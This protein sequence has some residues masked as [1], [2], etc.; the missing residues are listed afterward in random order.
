MPANPVLVVDDENTD[1]AAQSGLGGVIRCSFAC[2]LLPSTDHRGV[3]DGRPDQ[4]DE[5]ERLCKLLG[6]GRTMRPACWA[7]KVTKVPCRT[8]GTW[9]RPIG[10][11]GRSLEDPPCQGGLISTL[12]RTP[13]GEAGRRA[14]G[15]T[16]SVLRIRSSVAVRGDLGS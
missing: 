4:R 1:Q 6:H 8:D 9:D 16:R 5:R 11:V 13:Y 7:S 3:L 14:S 10:R 15:E 2:P 12:A